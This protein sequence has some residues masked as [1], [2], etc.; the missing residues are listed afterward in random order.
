MICTGS[1][2]TP[3]GQG[4][5]DLNFQAV[6][7]DSVSFR[8]VS[9]YDN[10]DDAVIIYGIKYW[11]GDNVFNQFVP[12]LVKR[13]RAVMPDTNTDNGLPAILSSFNFTSLDSRVKNAGKEFFYV[14]IALYTLADDGETQNLYG[15][16]YWDPSITVS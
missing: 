5:A 12:N 13:Q 2:G 7:G 14:Y 3:G 10:S 6:P 11:Q 15:Y 1:H 4:T 8:A 16:F 9:I